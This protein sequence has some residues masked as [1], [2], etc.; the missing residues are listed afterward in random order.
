MKNPGYEKEEI[1]LLKAE[2]VE[3]GLSFVMVEDEDFGED[4]ED[5]DQYVH[6]Q[7]VGMHEGQEVI[8]DTILSTLSMHHSALLYEAAEEKVM[9]IYKDFVPY[10]LRKPNHKP[11]EEA[12]QMIEEL[13]EEME[14][15]E[16][17]KVAEFVNKELDFEYGIGLEVGLNL[18]E[19]TIEDIESFI[20]DFNA[21]TLKLDKTLYSFKN[22]FED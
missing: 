4:F 14:D 9:K 10:E 7:F 13:I 22:G 6:F 8:Y 11:N 16:T 19:I 2:C 21:G 12:E 18:E 17:I 5:E 20:A 3:E 15:E 1:D